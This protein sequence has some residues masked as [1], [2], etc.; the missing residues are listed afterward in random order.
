M[1]S[2]TEENLKNAFA[3]ESQA[4]MKYQIFA[5][6]AD[7]EGF[8]NIAKLFRAI[9]Y[10]E[11]VHAKNHLNALDGVN[12]TPE[13]LDVAI[14]GENFEVNEMY[15]AY[16]TVAEQ[17]KEKKAIQSMHFA[18]EAEKIHAALYTEAKEGAKSGKDMDIKNIYIC[19]VCGYTTLGDAPDRCPVCNV[20][21]DK[22]KT[23]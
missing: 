1:H 6:R 11:L 12:Q 13:N 10:A 4:H 2:M 20:T 15:P 18:L 16:K 23:F 17:Q 3:G 14:E 22:F 19:S 21:I 9:A 8:K 5:E 7:E